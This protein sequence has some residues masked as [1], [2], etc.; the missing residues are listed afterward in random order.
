MFQRSMLLQAAVWI[1]Q[2]P[3]QELL[4]VKDRLNY[5]NT[6][7]YPWLANYLRTG[8]ISAFKFSDDNI[9]IKSM[10]L[11]AVILFS[12][13]CFIINVPIVRDKAS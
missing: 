2:Q 7:F 3:A 8:N 4:L 1:L 10:Q 5:V 12:I 9:V 11:K 13:F 6:A